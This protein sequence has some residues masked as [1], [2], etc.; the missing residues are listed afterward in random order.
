MIHQGAYFSIYIGSSGSLN[1]HHESR[2]WSPSRSLQYR[3]YSNIHPRTPFFWTNNDLHKRPL[4]F[5]NELTPLLRF[6]SLNTF[7][8]QLA[9]RLSHPSIFILSARTNYS[10]T[11][12]NNDWTIRRSSTAGDVTNTAKLAAFRTWVSRARCQDTSRARLRFLP[13]V[14]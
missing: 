4:S 12:A 1:G 11:F 10:N 8:L 14:S 2:Y 3:Q 9:R 6:Q 7:Q 5:H 13:T